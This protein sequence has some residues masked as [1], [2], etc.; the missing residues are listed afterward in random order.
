M[1]DLIFVLMSLFKRYFSPLLDSESE[2][3][4]KK[5]REREGHDMQQVAGWSQTSSVT[6]IRHAL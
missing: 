4:D 5:C 2:E 6:V 1:L 3:A